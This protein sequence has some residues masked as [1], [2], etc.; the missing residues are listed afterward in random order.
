[1]SRVLVGCIVISILTGLMFTILTL[2]EP[3][4]VSVANQYLDLICERD[5]EGI[6]RLLP[7]IWQEHITHSEILNHLNRLYDNKNLFHQTCRPLLHEHEIRYYVLPKHI[8]HLFD[9]AYSFPYNFDGSYSWDGTD[10][11]VEY[12]NGWYVIPQFLS[13]TDTFDTVHNLNEILSLDTSENSSTLSIVRHIAVELDKFWY[14]GIVAD[15]DWKAV[16]TIDSNLS[17]GAE[18]F[19]PMRFPPVELFSYVGTEQVDTFVD[20]TGDQQIV[21]WF[22]VTKSSLMGR[23]IE[24]V[25]L[26]IY[27][28]FSSYAG[29]PSVI[30]LDGIAKLN[31]QSI[32]PI[33]VEDVLYRQNDIDFVIEVEPHL[34]SFY[35]NCF[36]FQLYTLDNIIYPF[37]CLQELD[38]FQLDEIYF[39]PDSPKTRLIVT[40]T[41]SNLIDAQFDKDSVLYYLGGIDNQNLFSRLWS[42]EK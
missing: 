36:N 9:E 39:P 10:L 35:F 4:Y 24:D 41:G 40:F 20:A 26:Y 14:V 1:M 5:V 13:L 19:H 42:N 21:W 22:E 15:L 34:G 37:M 16:Q 25:R 27:S 18:V 12:E 2:P 17:I 30:S 28:F 6:R 29:I 38:R 3:E 33:S 31:S 32:I 8:S 23:D 11:L 7:P